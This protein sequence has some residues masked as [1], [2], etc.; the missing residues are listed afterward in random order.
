MKKIISMLCCACLLV[1]S[2]FVA[3]CTTPPSTTN[4]DKTVVYV[5]LKSGGTGVQWLIDAG[6]RF[7]AL[8]EKTVYEDG[9]EGVSI[10]PVPVED[11]SLKNAETSGSAIIDLMGMVNIENDARAGKVLCIDDVLMD[12]SD[13]REGTPISPLD[14]ISQDQRSRYM[15][16]GHYYGGP[17]CEY[18]PTISYDRNLFDRY[19]LYLVSPEVAAD[20]NNEGVIM[21]FDSEILSDTFYFLPTAG[22]NDAMKSCG[23]DG[24]YGTDDDGLPSSLYELIALCEYMKFKGINPFNFT[25]GYKY[26]SNFLLSALYTSLQGY[27][28]A[29]NN[30][31]FNGTSEIVVGFEDDYLFPGVDGNGDPI[32]TIKKPITKTVEISEENG[33]YTS[34]EVEKYYAEAFMDLCV[35]QSWFGPSVTNGDDQKAA[36]SKFVFS[37]FNGAEKI[38]MH[39]DGSYWYNEATEGDNYFQLLEDSKYLIAG[40]A[41]ERDVRV[42]PLPV[43]VKESVAEGE[44]KAQALLEMNYGMFVINKNVESN[45]GLMR[46]SKEFLKFLYTDAELSKYTASTSIVRSMNYELSSEDESKI[47]SYGKRLLEQISSGKSKVVYFADEN[48]TFKA[49]TGS[50]K[51]SWENAVFGVGSVSGNFYEAIAII[52]KDGYKT[53]DE[54]FTKQA[55][56]KAKWEGMYKGNGTVSDVDGLTD[57]TTL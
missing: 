9:K 40:M 53:V 19:C 10:V 32:S 57:L 3:G 31:E 54:I 2:S 24:E 56:N 17:T 28:G 41:E 27:E 13:M 51:Q 50:F 38:A 6:A 37:D 46:A 16:N 23:P 33:Y 7:S 14:K 11:P 4:D 25:G 39:L 21:A 12:E 8:N 36:M 49:N 1:S 35:K 43:N 22:N 42:M 18:Y 47:S 55:I 44:G 34:W 30:Y 52:K 15:Y 48:A 29:R 20:P 45:P 5:E 26:Y